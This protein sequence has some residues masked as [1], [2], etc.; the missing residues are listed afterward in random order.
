MQQ[1]TVDYVVSGE[2]E[3]PL[4]QLLAGGMNPTDVPGITYR[5]SGRIVTNPPA[6]EENLDLLGR[7]DFSDLDL[8]SYYSPLPVLPIAT[9][10]GCYW[11]RCA[12]C[13]H[14]RSA[15][16]TY[17]RCTVPGVVEQ[18]KRH[19][20][21]GVEHFALVDEMIA[22]AHFSQLAEGILDAGLRIRYYAMAKPVRQFDRDLL[23]KMRQSGCCYL[24]W[25]IESGAQRIL[26]LMDKGTKV[27][28]IEEVCR[29]TPKPR[30][31]HGRFSHRNSGRVPGDVRSLGAAS[32]RHLGGASRPFRAGKGVA[33]GR[34]SREVPD[35]PL[36][37]RGRTAPGQL[38]PL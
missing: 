3:G 36:V 1:P 27:A 17:R 21:N 28:E 37:A 20:E 35:Y 15:G 34:P 32:S 13:V 4:M 24:L 5:Q 31:H 23:R 29:E 9:S 14:Y 30:L 18:L 12:F 2:G 6:V 33:R 25:G 19:V 7:A 38:A 26:D 8:R 16:Q 11:R 22:P 10:R